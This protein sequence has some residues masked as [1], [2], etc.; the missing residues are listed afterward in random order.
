MLWET[1]FEVDVLSGLQRPDRGERVPVVRRRDRDRIDVARRE[2]LANVLVCLDVAAIDGRLDG[3]EYGG[4][5]IADGDDS[6]ARN[7]RETTEMILPSAVQAD[8]GD[9][10]I[11]VRPE[12]FTP[13][14]GRECDPRG[15]DQRCLDER[16][17]RVT[18][19]GPW[20]EEPIVNSE[21]YPG[22]GSGETARRTSCYLNV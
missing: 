6:H 20:G 16:A 17:T 4:I 22:C 13:R 14:A 12:H 9:A 18:G 21:D 5:G 8:D 10:E 15:A 1:G 19:H 2:E 7:L 3:V 11:T